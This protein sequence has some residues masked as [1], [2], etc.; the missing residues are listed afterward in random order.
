MKLKQCS[1]ELASADPRVGTNTSILFKVFEAQNKN[2]NKK[3]WV[4]SV[5]K[6]LE[7]IELDVTFANIQHMR[8]QQWKNIIKTQL[9]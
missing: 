2:R 8:K 3:D 4:T 9:Y 1:L 7:E 5:I 6:D